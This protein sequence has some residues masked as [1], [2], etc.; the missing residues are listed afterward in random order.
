M[1]KRQI[2]VTSKPI[3]PQF[4]RFIY[5]AEDIKNTLKINDKKPL[6]YNRENALK[7]YQANELNKTDNLNKRAANLHMIKAYRMADEALSKQ[8]HSG[9]SLIGDGMAIMERLNQRDGQQDSGCM[10]RLEGMPT[11]KTAIEKVLAQQC[12]DANHHLKTEF[13]DESQKSGTTYERVII[14]TRDPKKVRIFTVKAGDGDVFL[15]SQPKDGELEVKQADRRDRPDEP[16][17]KKRIEDL[18]GE[19]TYSD[20][21][22]V[23]RINKKLSVSAGFGDFKNPYIRREPR[24]QYFEFPVK[25]GKCD[26]KAVIVNC[27]GITERHKTIE[28]TKQMIKS[29]MEPKKMAKKP[30]EI[31]EGLIGMAEQSGSGDNLSA[32]VIKIDEL[33]K[34]PL[35]VY[36]LLICDG[37]GYHGDI[38][39]RAVCEHHSNQ[40]F[41]FE[42]TEDQQEEEDS[43]DPIDEKHQKRIIQEYEELRISGYTKD[44][45]DQLEGYN[46]LSPSHKTQLG[47]LLKMTLNALKDFVLEKATIDRLAREIQSAI[48]PI[49]GR[50]EISI[51]P[52][53]TWTQFFCCRP[54]PINVSRLVLSA[55]QQQKLTVIFDISR[56][57]G[58][59]D[60]ERRSKT[61]V[62]SDHKSDKSD[63]SS[64]ENYF[65]TDKNSPI[66]EQNLL[67]NTPVV[68]NQPHPEEL[69]KHPQPPLVEKIMDLLDQKEKGIANYGYSLG[70]VGKVISMLKGYND[71]SKDHKQQLVKLLIEFWD[72][73]AKMGLHFH[74]DTFNTLAREV[75]SAMYTFREKKEISIGSER[76]WIPLFNSQ[77][78][79][80]NTSRLHSCLAIENRLK[81]HST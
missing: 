52:I 55:Q 14:D 10:N 65:E 28:K 50:T 32:G 38:M 18:G 27:D 8:S 12:K 56:E 37:H 64:N 23:W 80:I 24:I 77:P 66:L 33:L 15:V 17:E 60:L 46:D 74:K 54:H 13:Y 81:E 73:N 3:F 76:T 63:H 58:A 69:V 22:D 44:I 51:E 67:S 20:V 7:I 19:V 35:G 11:E 47:K 43:K 72:E 34:Q 42:V 71:L 70:L 21:S 48:Y 61:K 9:H 49:R 26:L 16:D 40:S 30:E 68:S 29:L 59:A 2:K 39:S 57:L 75:Q 5:Q 45:L 4:I 6:P 62:E 41:N 36:D 53:R 79:P 31:S 1:S 25:D 78:H